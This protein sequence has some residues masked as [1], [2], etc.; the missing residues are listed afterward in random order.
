MR[1]WLSSLRRS[2]RSYGKVIRALDSLD[3]ERIYVE[4]VRV[5]CGVS[6]SDAQRMLDIGVRDGSFEH[7]VGV[8]CPHEEHIVQSFT[9]GASI[10]EAVHCLVCEAEGRDFQHRTEGM[11]RLPFYRFVQ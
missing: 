11:E 9:F 6:R 3:A 1:R 10:P 2:R 7:R 4:N 8:L 5:I